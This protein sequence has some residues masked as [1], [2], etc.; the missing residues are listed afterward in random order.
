MVARPD[1][2]GDQVVAGVVPLAVDEL[3]EVAAYL[4]HGPGDAAARSA[5]VPDH[6][7][8]PVAEV[9]LVL[10]RDAEQI[11]DRVDGQREG[12]VVDEVGLPFAAKASIRPSVNSCTRGSNSATRRGVNACETSRRSRVWSGGSM[13][14]RCV[15]NSAPRSPG[16]P[17]S[18]W[19]AP[20]RRGAG[21]LGQP[22]IGE[23][24]PGVRVPRHEPRVDPAGQPGAVYGGVLAQPGVGGVGV[25]GELPGEE[26]GRGGRCAGAGGA[27]VTGRWRL[28]PPPR[29]SRHGRCGPP[30]AGRPPGRRPPV[31]RGR[32]GRGARS[33]RPRPAGEGRPGARR[34]RG[35]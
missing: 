19:R 18:P 10:A 2:A 4:L 12:E 14:S 16:S 11:A 23:G 30:R 13:F 34:R 28:R 9:V 22:G 5:A 31:P 24:T 3:G 32:P 27:A 21:V 26:F 17:S 7:P 20:A 1:Q 35:R 15:I 25:G 6:H 33:R 29:G 8:G